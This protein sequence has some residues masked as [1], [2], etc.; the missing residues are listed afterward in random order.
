MLDLVQLLRAYIYSALS[1]VPGYKALL[2]DKDTMR[3]CSMLLGRSELA[4]RD[5]VH[6][7]QLDHPTSSKKSHQELKVSREL[8]IP[9]EKKLQ[10]EHTRNDALELQ[11]VSSSGMKLELSAS[12]Q[13]R[14]GK[15]SLCQLRGCVR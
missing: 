12:P 3:M 2:V 1:A 5:V 6:V 8:F 4:D 10:T 14:K 9:Y 7:E 15:K 11:V 13:E